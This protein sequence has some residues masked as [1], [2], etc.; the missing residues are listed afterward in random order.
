[1]KNKRL[2]LVFMA[3]LMSNALLLAQVR[4]TITGTVTDNTGKPVP[5]ATVA[6][7]GTTT[8]VVTDD[9]GRFTLTTDKADAVLQ[10]SSVS[11]TAI[12]VPASGATVNATLQPVAGDLGEVVVTALGIRKAKKSVGYAVQEVKGTTLVGAREPNLVNALSGQVA[13]LQVVRSSNGPA[14]S[15]KIILRGN[16]SLTG[17]NQPLIVVDGIPVDNFTGTTNNDYWNPGTDMGNGLSDIN[18]EDIESLSVLKGP[19]AAALYGSRAGNGVILITTKSGRKQNGLGITVTSSIGVESIFTN[20]D[21]QNSFGQ[22]LDNIYD[23]ASQLSWGPKATGQNVTNWN[24]QTVPLRTY[25]NVKNYFDKGITQNHGV[26]FQQ[27][28]KSTSIYTSFNR[29]EDRSMIPNVKLTRTN[30]LARAVSKFGKNDKWTSDTKV[31]YSNSDAENRPIN[32]RDNSSAFVLYMLPR[33]MDIR[34]F[35]Q[36]TD[37][38]GNMIWYPGGGNQINPYWR[39]TYDQNQDVRDRFLLNGSLKYDFTSWLNMEVKAGADMY[40]TNTESK[41]YAGSPITPTGRYSLGKQTFTETNYSTLINARKDNLAGRLGGNLTLG[42][43][44]MSQKWSSIGAN[45]GILV[46]PNLFSIN[47]G[48]ANPTVSE[49]FTQRKI[50]SLYGTAGINWDGWAFL[51]ATFRND[52]SST[53]SKSNRSFFYPSVS[54][55][56]IVTDMIGKMGGNVPAWISYAKVRGSYAQVGNDLSPYQLYN[57]FLIG[58]D[59]NGNTTATRN[60][61]LFDEDV[62]SELI[63]SLEVGAEVRF[64]NNRVGFDF[65]YYKS[66]ATNQLIDVAMDPLSGYSFRK[67]N[68]GDI[69]NQGIELM[70]DGRVLSN[71][72]GF[73]W[74]V[75][76]NYS[77]NKNDIK[78]LS[79]EFGINSY[80]LGGF[81]DVSV[82]A[83]T[84]ARYGEIYGTK[85]VRVKDAASPFFGQVVLD[86]NGLPQRDPEIQRLGNQQATG[87]LGV[88]NSFSYKGFGLSFLIDARFG[89]KIF[90]ATHVAMQLNGTSAVTAPNGERENFVVDGV[91][92]NGSGGYTKNAIAVSPQLYWRAVAG[93]NNLG[94]T[95]ANLYDADNVRLRNVQL[96]YDLP[97]RLLSRTPIQ[98]AKIGVSANN[99]WLIKSK[100]NGIDPESVFATG[101]NA[102]GFENAGIPTTRTIL[103]NLA[104]TF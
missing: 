89:G 43:N 10:I 25:D 19:S 67:V 17:S 18:A 16:N 37:Q 21:M 15:S 91:V 65:A 61:T 75:M 48:V 1:M 68:A 31:Q 34:Q 58:K 55:A 39:N 36:S 9:N 7:K 81:D 23:P 3:L 82:L 50:N 29:L 41:V 2:L 57:T 83:V 35:K 40:T 98:R 51:D 11:F 74:N 79:P 104:L 102:V 84:G 53:L 49:G 46:V 88:T 92:S 45:S 12:E 22:G 13:G 64:L 54:A 95:E 14:G 86:A 27:Q 69:Q 63:K 60:Q 33:S 56:V 20:P 101:S 52:W 42:G 71:P 77:V 28:Y 97:L 90:S 96:S 72:N 94:I 85:F 5:S 93:A 32:G 78:E 99:V 8:T 59:P 76:V 70:V 24:G 44:L 80:R 62:Q 87:L 30:L 6:I 100:M 103:F 38:N 26:S 73:N 4:R 47:N 66:N